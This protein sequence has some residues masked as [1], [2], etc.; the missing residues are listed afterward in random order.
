MSRFWQQPP[1]GSPWQP[2]ILLEQSEETGDS[3][4]SHTPTELNCG[5]IFSSCLVWGAE[6]CTHAHAVPAEVIFSISETVTWM[7]PCQ[8]WNALNCTQL[9]S[10]DSWSVL[11]S[12]PPA[13]PSLEWIWVK[14]SQPSEIRA[15]PWVLAQ[16]P[17]V[18]AQLEIH[19]KK[20]CQSPGELRLGSV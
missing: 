6:P 3:L 15:V 19:Q 2:H 7:V 8:W 12:C 13:F 16:W 17:G 9:I 18:G 1:A 5:S 20:P 4:G 10:A 14:S 11:C